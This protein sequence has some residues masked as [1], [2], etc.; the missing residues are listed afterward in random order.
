MTAAAV[1]CP[2]YLREKHGAEPLH[3]KDAASLHQ[4]VSIGA[5]AH[6][7]PAFKLSLFQRG[8]KFG[9]HSNNYQSLAKRMV[10]CRAVS[11]PI[12]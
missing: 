1:G 6:H 12:C 8:H 7:S 3:G 9:N 11:A 2:E 4:Q 5:L 10:P